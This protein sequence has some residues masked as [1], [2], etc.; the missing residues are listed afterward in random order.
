[1]R[2]AVLA[3]GGGSNLQALLDHILSGELPAECVFVAS[4][5]SKA[6]ALE[7]ARFAGI[8]AYHVS[9]HNE[10]VKRILEGSPLSV[11]FR[12]DAVAER[13]IEL[14]DQYR[15]DLLVLAGYMKK[16]PE[17]VLRR[18]LNRVINI[19]PAL[20]PAFGGSGYYGEKVHA[21]VLRERHP[22]TGVTIHMVNEEY[23]EGQIV[24]QRSVPVPAG[25]DLHALAERVLA[26]EHD[27]YWRV[28]K[29]F[30]QGKILPTTSTNPSRAVDIDPQWLSSVQ[31]LDGTHSP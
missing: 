31:A 17:A 5:N 3:S 6:G 16:V 10:E 11:A 8:P 29:A 19:H 30:A 13:L 7:R 1:V 14:I 12:E 21:A 28:L 15:V 20:L 18:L 25:A 2:F 23:D 27:S 26:K 22:V 9:V 24:L 4:N